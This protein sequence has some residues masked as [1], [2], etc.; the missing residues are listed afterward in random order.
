MKKTP[1]LIP[2]VILK[3]KNCYNAFSPVIDGCVA[4][5]K[6]VDAVLKD[7]KEAIEFHLEGETL[8]KGKKFKVTKVLKEAFE[9]YDTDA[10][11]AS[12]KVSA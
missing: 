4:T 1:L 6:S 11:Y 10:L 8:V 9:E 7:I 12:V 3:T 5:N 2:V